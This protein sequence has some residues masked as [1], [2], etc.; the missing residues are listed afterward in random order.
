MYYTGPSFLQNSIGPGPLSRRPY[1]TPLSLQI[2]QQQPQYTSVCLNIILN[3]CYFGKLQVPKAHSLAIFIIA[4][5][6]LK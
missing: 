1:A 2:N 3:V 4:V 6:A 5:D